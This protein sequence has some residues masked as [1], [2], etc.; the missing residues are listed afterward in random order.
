MVQITT[1]IYENKKADSQVKTGLLKLGS[2]FVNEY[3]TVCTMPSPEME[4]GIYAAYTRRRADAP[5]I[6]GDLRKRNLERYTGIEP[7]TSSLGILYRI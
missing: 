3:R 6:R 5:P 2:P 4:S 1:A 7:V